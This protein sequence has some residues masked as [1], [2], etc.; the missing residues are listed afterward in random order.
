MRVVEEMLTTKLTKNPASLE[1]LEP[2]L[3]NPSEEAISESNGIKEQHDTLKLQN[4]KVNLK[5][6]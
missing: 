5:N 3:N 4:E 6:T 2:Y 1:I